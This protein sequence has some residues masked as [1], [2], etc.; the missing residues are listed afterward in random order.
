VIAAVSVLALLAGAVVLVLLVSR[1]DDAASSGP[2]AL[3]APIWFQRVAAENPGAC[4]S[5][6]T[7]ATDAQTCYQLVP[8]G[9]LA[10]GVNAITLQR[11]DPGRGRTGWSIL[12]ELLRPAVPDFARLST[13]AAAAEPGQPQ[14]QIAMVVDGEVVSAPSVS[15][16]ITDGRVE[17]QGLW[18]EKTAK[19][20]FRKLTGSDG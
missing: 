1:K 12:L 20:L 3:K 19:Q 18:D 4:S 5:G 16:P 2:R 13:A 15:R 9:V 8:G 14:N 17:I 7:P 6:G 11:P 10:A